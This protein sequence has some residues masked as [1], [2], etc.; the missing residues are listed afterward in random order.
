MKNTIHSIKT[1]LAVLSLLTLGACFEER[2]NSYSEEWVAFDDDV[3]TRTEGSTGDISVTLLHSG[4]L[5]SNDIVINYTVSSTDAIEG[6]DYTVTGDGTITIPAGS[7][8]VTFPVLATIDNDFQQPNRTVT[9]T[10]QSAGDIPIGFPGPDGFHKSVRVNIIDDDCADDIPKISKWIGSITAED[11][12]FGEY[13]ATGSA[14]DDGVCGGEL[15][16]EGDI[17]GFGLNAK[18]KIVFTQDA[19]G[20]PTGEAVVVRDIFF[21]DPA[22]SAY[23]YEA[24]GTYD[25]DTKTIVISYLF[26][27]DDGSVWFPGVHIIKAD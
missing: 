17:L 19:E 23:E 18:I 16:V 4:A 11:E 5:R 20:T 15:I 24:A 7:S 22:Y 26:Y 12:G 1:I 25:E 10:L 14:G 27:D 8:S 9:V 13:P 21:T 3:A 6:E 2:D